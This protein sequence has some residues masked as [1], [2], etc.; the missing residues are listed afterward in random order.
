M[1]T[2]RVK[3]SYRSGSKYLR[4]EKEELY[5]YSFDKRHHLIFYETPIITCVCILRD[6]EK[7]GM[8][9]R[10]VYSEKPP[11]VE[12]KLTVLGK[13]SMRVIDTLQRFGAHLMKI[14]GL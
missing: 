2:G 7:K 11:R 13:K 14:N 12:Y 5:V 4:Q 8:I 9:E 6:L 10:K 3:M 1:K